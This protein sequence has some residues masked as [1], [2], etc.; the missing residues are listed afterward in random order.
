MLALITRPKEDAEATAQAFR[1]RGF[2]VLLAPLTEIVTRPGLTLGL[3]GVQGFLITSANGARALAQ[4]TTARN[5]AVWA[6]GDASAAVAR[7][8]GFRQVH[9]AQ[10][11]VS[12]LAHLVIK[13]ADPAAGPLIHAAASEVAGDL[14]G[15]L[16]QAGFMVRR[17]ILYGAQPVETLPEPAR[18]ALS[19]KRVTVAP[20]YSP[21]TA[22]AFTALSLAAGITSSHLAQATALALSPAVARALD[23]LNWGHLITAQSPNQNSLLAAL[24]Q[25]GLTA[26]S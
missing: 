4:T 17:E 19:T 6:V 3:D 10:G 5:L 14:S 11:D 9:S 18:R 8:L 12:T 21:R 22:A 7:D 13:N 1:E 25:T 20:F 16:T 2:D 26:D 24:D 23:G 15:Q